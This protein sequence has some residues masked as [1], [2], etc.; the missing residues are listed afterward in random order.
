[1]RLDHEKTVAAAVARPDLAAGAI[2]PLYK[3]GTFP[4][5]LAGKG[6]IA[7][8]SRL[9]GRELQRKRRDPSGEGLAFFPAPVGSQATRR[10]E[11]DHAVRRTSSNATVRARE[12]VMTS[13]VVGDQVIVRYGTHQGQRGE[14]IKTQQADV[15]Q[16]KIEDGFILFF[17]AKGLETVELGLGLQRH[18]NGSGR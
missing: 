4:G 16:V 17:S 11:P 18:L 8:D 1:M 14:I 7:S 13:F 2:K 10:F 15:Y 5:Y 12:I 3:S 9:N 6:A